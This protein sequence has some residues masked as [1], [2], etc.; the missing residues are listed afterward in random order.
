MC[1][2][3]VYKVSMVKKPK[4]LWI[5]IQLKFGFYELHD[6]PYWGKP[7]C[8]Q[9]LSHSHLSCMTR[10]WILPKGRPNELKPLSLMSRHCFKTLCKV[11]YKCCASTVDFKL[12]FQLIIWQFELC[13]LLGWLLSLKPKYLWHL[14]RKLSR[15]N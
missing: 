7:S 1:W 5:Q 6:H 4:W 9:S 13:C 15:T 11:I 10:N 12:H 3:I 2:N 14:K 8:V